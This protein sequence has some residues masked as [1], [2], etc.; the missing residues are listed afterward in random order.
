MSLSEALRH[1]TSIA[2]NEVLFEWL[3]VAREDP[4]ALL[5]GDELGSTFQGYLSPDILPEAE[6]R[7]L[8]AEIEAWDPGSDD[9]SHAGAVARYQQAQLAAAI[10]VSRALVALACG[11]DRIPASLAGQVDELAPVVAIVREALATGDV[12]EV[13]DI[14]SLLDG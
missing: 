3:D 7:R 10:D 1:A 13:L 8:L 4:V 12:D 5:E 2:A 11:L 9:G 14:E 6:A